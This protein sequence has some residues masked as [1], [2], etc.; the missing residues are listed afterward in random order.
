MLTPKET[1]AAVLSKSCSEQ[2]NAASLF[3]SSLFGQLFEA[4][5]KRLYAYIFA[6]LQEK[7]TTDDVFQECC[8]TL[9]QEFEK[10]EPGTNFS[11][12]AN[13]IAF[14]RIQAFRRTHQRYELGQSNDFI[15]EFS[16]NLVTI[17]SL[18]LPQEQKWLYLERCCSLLPPP[19]QSIY[20]SFYKSNQT[21]QEIAD[22]SGR[23][24][25]AIR[26]AVHKLRKKLFD[27]VEEKV[28]EGA[29]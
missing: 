27:C 26:K 16:Q 21:A 8:L 15:Q 24:I 14:N 23:S 11:K 1:S 25:R 7:P 22:T 4:D 10:F 3:H 29:A 6:Y 13:S 19:L 12:W 20:Q 28:K 5:K 9:W 2:Q 18:A 17:E